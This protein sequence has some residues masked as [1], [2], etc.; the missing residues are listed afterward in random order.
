LD[1]AKAPPY[2]KERLNI[3]E[4]EKV[5]GGKSKLIIIGLAL[6]LVMAVA[7]ISTAGPA[8]AAQLLQT[9]G[10]HVPGHRISPFQKGELFRITGSGTAFNVTDRN[11]KEVATLDLMISVERASFGRAKISVRTGSLTVGGETFTVESGRGIGNTHSLKMLIHVTLKDTSGNTFH[12]VLNGKIVRPLNIN[13]GL[14]IDFRMPQS[15][16]AG[17]W[18]LEFPQ[19]TMAKI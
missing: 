7:S 9:P 8:Y 17:K 15:K 3:L 1:Y 14:T 6:V 4:E 13:N 19:A 10:N 5:F 18:F 11:R 12:M 2:P 16:L